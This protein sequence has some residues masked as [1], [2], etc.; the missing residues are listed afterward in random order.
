M[1]KVREQ[2]QKHKQ[3]A[4]KIGMKKIQY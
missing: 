2:K 3:K 4:K 1:P